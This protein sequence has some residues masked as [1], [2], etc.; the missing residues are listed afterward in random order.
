MQI[1]TCM[2]INKRG[3]DDAVDLSTGCPTR[4][5]LFVISSFLIPMDDLSEDH[6]LCITDITACVRFLANMASTSHAWNAYV[7]KSIGRFNLILHRL[8]TRAP[9][10]NTMDGAYQLYKFVSNRIAEFPKRSRVF[11]QI[12][13]IMSVTA[14][15]LVKYIKRSEA[16][17]ASHWMALPPVRGGRELQIDCHRQLAVHLIGSHVIGD[18]KN[19]PFCNEV[20]RRL[21]TG[22]HSAFDKDLLPINIIDRRIAGYQA[23]LREART[24][25]LSQVSLLPSD[26]F[27]WNRTLVTALTLQGRADIL[28]VL[29]QHPI[30]VT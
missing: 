29:L 3:R 16:G 7:H 14:Q 9:P 11:L 28:N 15:G 6:K 25:G 10:K 2:S 1:Y 23:L 5:V 30:I 17:A 13:G 24:Y 27:H 19:S 21:Q 4:D 22:D 8:K 20:T 18:V 26:F 12:L